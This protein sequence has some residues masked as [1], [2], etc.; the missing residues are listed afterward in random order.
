M[1]E[2]NSLGNGHK[3]LRR[4]V[5]TLIGLNR[6]NNATWKIIPWIL[7][8]SMSENVWW[9]CYSFYWPGGF[10]PFLL[11]NLYFT[12]YKLSYLFL[13]W[14]WFEYFK[15]Y[16]SWIK[17][18]NLNLTCLMHKIKFSCWIYNFFF[19][20][21]FI[22]KSGF[23]NISSPFYIFIKNKMCNHEILNWLMSA[24]LY[25]TTQMCLKTC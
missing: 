20:Y 18:G 19:S 25:D 11:G 12:Y 13:P 6:W 8:L 7:S 16:G 17:M 5:E 2:V 1:C 14:I 23:Y 21:F 10:G 15:W 9:W 22:L 4:G 3:G 24:I